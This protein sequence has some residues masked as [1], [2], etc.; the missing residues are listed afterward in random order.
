MSS[1]ASSCG[2]LVL[3]ID[4]DRGSNEGVMNPDPSMS[5]DDWMGEVDW[6]TLCAASLRRLAGPL[7][8]SF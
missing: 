1:E 4:D 8:P 5:V 6:T 2:L 3:E 7:P